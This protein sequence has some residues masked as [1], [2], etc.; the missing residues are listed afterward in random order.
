MSEF[1]E[2]ADPEIEERLAYLRGGASK[3][4]IAG[5]ASA[6]FAG[7]MLILSLVG[8]AASLALIMTEKMHLRDPEAALICDVNPFIGC[9]DWIGAWQNEV[10]FG[11]SNSVL[12]FAAFAALAFFSLILLT[13][14]Q[15]PAVNWRLV[16]CG[17]ALADIWLLWFIYQSLFIKTVLCPYCVM[18]WI[19]TIPLTYLILSRSFQAGHFGNGRAQKLGEFLVRNQGGMLGG[20]YF[21]LFATALFNLWDAISRL[22]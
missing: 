20:I 8:G 5:G 17:A 15:L 22:F 11:I 2:I 6:K 13:G 18:I 1:E 12:G 21:I 10:F 4:Q 16:S 9:G 19:V 14:A 7:I 3:H